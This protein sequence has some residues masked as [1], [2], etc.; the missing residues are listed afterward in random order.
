MTIESL[1]SRLEAGGVTPVTPPREAGVTRKPAPVLACTRVTPV[2]PQNDE[3]RTDTAGDPSIPALPGAADPEALREFLEER[4]AI[5][6]FDGGCS[7]EDA[8][9]AALEDLRGQVRATAETLVERARRE[10]GLTIADERLLG[11]DCEGNPYWSAW[12]LRELF[13]AARKRH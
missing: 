11:V 2:T 10:L 12:V 5:R 7:R 4:A 9:A 13:T 1:L 3:S 8:E 6:E